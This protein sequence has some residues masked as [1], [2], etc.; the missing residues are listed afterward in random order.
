MG[1]LGRAG[2]SVSL[3]SRPWVRVVSSGKSNPTGT[4]LVSHARVSFGYTLTAIRW[5]GLAAAA[6]TEAGR[7]ETNPLRTVGSLERTLTAS[8]AKP[9]AW[10]G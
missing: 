5:S 8:V 1:N 9:A 4:E 10:L 2:D 7:K 3:E 6:M